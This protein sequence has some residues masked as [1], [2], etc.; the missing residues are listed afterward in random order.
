MRS[1][2]P[3][4]SLAILAPFVLAPLAAS[5]LLGGVANVL[6]SLTTIGQLL[7]AGLGV[8]ALWAGLSEDGH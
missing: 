4:W 2:T 1:A 5:G 6:P 8:F 3:F 7:V